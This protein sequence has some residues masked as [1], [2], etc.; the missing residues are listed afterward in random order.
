MR[1]RCGS[2]RVVPH[3]SA[4]GTDGK[5]NKLYSWYYRCQTCWHESGRLDK[6]KEPPLKGEIKK[7]ALSVKGVF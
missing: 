5:G 2:P 4:Y 1:C 3:G 6:K 7:I